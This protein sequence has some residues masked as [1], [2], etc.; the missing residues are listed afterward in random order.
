MKPV[1]GPPGTADREALLVDSDDIEGPERH[2]SGTGVAV[3]PG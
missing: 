2:R 3:R 1:Y